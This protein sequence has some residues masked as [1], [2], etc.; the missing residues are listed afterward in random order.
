MT[1]QERVTLGAVDARSQ[2][3]EKQIAR[4][5]KEV[6]E[7]RDEIRDDME[8]VHEENKAIYELVGSVKVIANRM[9]NV[10][11]TV[12]ETNKKLNDYS[13]KQQDSEDRLMRKITDIENAPAKKSMD[14]MDKIKLAIA[15]SV[16]SFLVGGV[17]ASVINFA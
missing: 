9:E 2:A 7:L 13:A 11:Q 5:H 1:D 4:L 3:N 10:E 15:T 12:T 14:F 6:G 8:K 17:L 16:V